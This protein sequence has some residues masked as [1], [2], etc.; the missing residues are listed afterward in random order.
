MRMELIEQRAHPSRGE[1][2]NGQDDHAQFTRVVLP[3]LADAYALAR[4]LTGDRTDAEDVV[5]D[6]CVR[7]FRG[8]AGFRGDNAR[9]WVLTIVRNT[10]YT[11]L[12]KNRSA[13]LVVT[14]DVEGVEGAEIPSA[15]SADAE[16]IA[17]ADVARLEAAIEKL[18]PSFRETLVL[19]DLQGLD[20]RQIAEVTGVP[21]GT[22]MSRLARARQ[23][24]MTMIAKDA[25]DAAP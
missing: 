9:A 11:W 20:Y 14:D 19:R 2:V 3:H 8:I 4:W 13:T 7:A 22:V 12:G 5:Q 21:I 17:G 24:L 25:N 16:L 23:R 6:A 10:A 15:T 1:R 18:P